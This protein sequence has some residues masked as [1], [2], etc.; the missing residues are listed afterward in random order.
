MRY[1]GR[2]GAWLDFY[3]LRAG[4]VADIWKAVYGDQAKDRL[5]RVVATQTGVSGRGEYHPFLGSDHAGRLARPGQRI[6][7]RWR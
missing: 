1:W 5:V 3:A 4:E 7:M 2:E 6:L